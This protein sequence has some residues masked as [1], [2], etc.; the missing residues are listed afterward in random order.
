[1]IK[2]QINQKDSFY[3]ELLNLIGYD[4]AF[5]NSPI[6]RLEKKTN[7]SNKIDKN[8]QEKLI[9]LKHEIN[10]IEDCKLKK[11]CF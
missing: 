6:N 11:K 1:M 10:S 8:K 2:K 3:I 5:N 9:E 4:Y 7:T